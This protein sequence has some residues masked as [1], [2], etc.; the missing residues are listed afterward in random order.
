MEATIKGI[1]ITPIKY[2]PYIYII[3]VDSMVF[4]SEH[5]SL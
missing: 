2:K 4:I 5:E 3:P 1:Y